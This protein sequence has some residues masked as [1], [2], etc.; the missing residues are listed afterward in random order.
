MHTPFKRVLF[1]FA[2]FV[3]LWA[4][5]SASLQ[6]Q[7]GSNHGTMLGS[8]TDPSGAVVP[9]AKVSI[10]NPVSGFSRNAVSDNAG[11]Y[12]FD[13]VPF[14]PYHVTV[15][16]EGFNAYAT[17][18]DV[19]S[20]VQREYDVI[21]R[22]AEVMRCNGPSCVVSTVLG[23]EVQDRLSSWIDRKALAS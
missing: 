12:E 18:V 23:H 11:H 21:V 13:N 6:A 19:R 2:A 15:M 22:G 7:S 5:G 4:S 20:A 10:L 14:D 16:A 1:A 17:D 9:G 3:L 8:V